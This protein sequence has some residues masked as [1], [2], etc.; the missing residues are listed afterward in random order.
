[1]SAATVAA[2]KP[3][4]VARGSSFY[5]AM[6]LMPEP[7]RSAM[8]AIYGFCRAVD[9]IADSEG[10]VDARRVALAA[11]RADIDR[12]YAGEGATP[13]HLSG[14]A[15]AVARFALKRADLAAVIDGMLMDVD[16]PMLAPDKATLDLYCD[17]VAAA[18]GR[19]SVR[20]FGMDEAAGIE[21][22]H[23]L[24]RA[25]QLTNILRD[26]DEDGGVGRVYLPREALAAAGVDVADAASI[27]ADTSLPHACV[28][29]LGQAKGHFAAARAVM[30]LERRGNHAA[31]RTPRLMC[32]AYWLILGKLESRGFAAPRAPLP[33]LGK[34]G[35]L[36]MLARHLAPW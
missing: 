27:L 22:S 31:I 3:Q 33:R 14:L 32:D 24:G 29:V 23:H 30:D 20:I 19:S 26:I 36:R 8:Y 2:P 34:L 15:A 7:R 10:P 5:L 12:L 25:M 11:W 17:R 1:M 35:L 28:N 18:V 21:L 13:P 6:R 16:G 9:D 4:G